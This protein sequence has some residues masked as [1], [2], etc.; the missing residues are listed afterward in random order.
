MN[1]TA[2]NVLILGV[3]VLSL[4][5]C[6]FSPEKGDP[7]PPNYGDYKEPTAPES[8]LNNLQVSYRRRE[9]ERYAQILAPEFI[10]RFQ[11]VDQNEIGKEFWTHDEDSVGTRALLTT[12]EV[13]EIRISLLFSTQDTTVN[14]PGT[15]IDS[16]KIRI[17]TTNLEVDQTNEV[18]WVVS[19]QQDMFFRL[20]KIENGEDPTHW[21]LYQWDDL[22]SL[23]SPG[24]SPLSTGGSGVQPIRRSWG[25]VLAEAM[26]DASSP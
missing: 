9:I 21:F 2:R 13:T 10:F 24:L 22:P 14:F 7:P 8:L 26:K 15:P 6:I 23:A 19:D 3:A 1:R 5:G 16:V 18:S 17:L 12:P 11:P 25:G 20:G 4:K